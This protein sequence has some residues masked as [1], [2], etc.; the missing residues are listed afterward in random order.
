MGLTRDAESASCRVAG[1]VVAF[2]LAMGGTLGR[3]F[4]L[5]GELSTTYFGKQQRG[6][7]PMPEAEV[8]DEHA[9]FL[10]TVGVLADWYVDPS[11]GF[12]VQG[13]VG[14]GALRLS[15]T[16]DSDY[17]ASGTVVSGGIGHEWW[18]GPE[19]SL[20]ILVRVD[21]ASLSYRDD[22]LQT[23]HEHRI[24]HVGLAVTATY[25]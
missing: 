3:G 4:V 14:A 15:D 9:A 17:V 23:D 10:S 11:K 12:H 20:G 13:V 19:T 6:R 16:A 1:P 18:M 22:G 5:G 21:W 7:L 24:L 25:H 2:D 8:Q